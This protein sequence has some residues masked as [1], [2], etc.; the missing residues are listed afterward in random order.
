MIPFATSVFSGLELPERL[1]R[2]NHPPVFGLDLYDLFSRSKIVFNG[3]IDMAR[4][5]RGNM[6][7]FEV[8][9]CGAI[10][11]SDEGIYPDGFIP[12]THFIVYKNK[13][14]VI[15]KVVEILENYEE[16]KSKGF[17]GAYMLKSKYSKEW[18]WSL[19]QKLVDDL[20]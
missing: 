8:M 6:R 19:F 3:A 16:H 1:L 18:Q 17:A 5:Y 10:M 12:G 4:E 7:C 14:D 20:G 13:T 11:L 15:P 9:G 2:I